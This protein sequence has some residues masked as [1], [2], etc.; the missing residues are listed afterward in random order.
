MVYHVELRCPGI[1]DEKKLEAI[2]RAVHM[3]A[4]NLYGSAMLVCGNDTR[5]AIACYSEDFISGQEQ[6][7]GDI[8]NDTYA[9]EENQSDD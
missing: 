4:R 2:K 7:L 8:N 6:I 5:P 9:E 3:H 1:T